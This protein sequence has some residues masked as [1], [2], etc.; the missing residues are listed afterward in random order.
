MAVAAG[1]VAPLGA[2]GADLANFA[3]YVAWSG[4]VLALAV[5]R[6]RL[7]PAPA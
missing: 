6:D 2:P 5:L 4:W 7:L 1:V 3:G